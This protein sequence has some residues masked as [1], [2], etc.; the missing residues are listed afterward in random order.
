ARIHVTNGVAYASQHDNLVFL[1]RGII[2]ESGSYSEIRMKPETELY[3]LITG[4]KSLSADQ[5]RS[6]SGTATPVN[7]EGVMIDEDDSS[8]VKQTVNEQ[9]KRR[10]SQRPPSFVSPETQKALAGQSLGHAHKTMQKELS[11]QGEVKWEVYR[12]YM[13]AASAVGFASY[14]LCILGQQV[15]TV[16]SNWVLKNWGENNLSEHPRPAGHYLAWYGAW[17]AASAVVSVAAGILLMV[18][19]ALRS[20]K[21]L[22]ERMLSSILRAPLQFFESTPQGRILNLFSRDIYT[23]DEVLVRVWSAFFRCIATVGGIFIVII[24]SF[25]SSLVVIFPLAYLY[26]VIMRWLAVRLE[27][28]GGLIVLVTSVLSLMSLFTNGN[29]DAGLVGFVLSYALS[30]TQALNWVVRCAGEVEQNIVSVERILTYIGLAPEAPYEI[31][32]TK[33]SQEWPSKGEIEFRDYSMRYRPDLD[34]CLNSLNLRIN[35]GERIGI[36]GR[37]GAGKSSSTLA[38]LRIL[39]ADAGS[40]L[41]DGVDISKIGLHD[42]RSAI[43][44]IPQEPQLFEGTI[45]QNVDPTGS[46]DDQQIWT[47]LEHSHLKEYVLSLDGGL[48]AVVREGGSSLSAG[49]RQLLCFARALL[50]KSKILI[51]DE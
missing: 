25:P 1:R 9:L 30:T 36:C 13:N 31:P 11:E 50:R 46:A 34:R 44:I 12:Q 23:V 27:F 38:L 40:I 49:Q 4:A 19:M 16:A 33:P 39:E 8:A 42:L 2:L 18:T 20:S 43:S 28:V 41:I 45:R 48:D 7:S 5:S 26:R 22:H 10:K 29:V 47:A 6:A 17:V 37:T 21:N 14:L 3:K 15:A 51:L 32:E 24:L 35:G